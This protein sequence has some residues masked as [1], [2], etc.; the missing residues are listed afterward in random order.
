MSVLDMLELVDPRLKWAVADE[1]DV[2]PAD[3]L[4]GAGGTQAP[5]ARLYVDYLGGVEADGLAY[6]RAPAFIERSANHVGIGTRRPRADNE[7]IGE[8]QAVND[9]TK[10]GHDESLNGENVV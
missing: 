9:G 1:L 5:V 7:G 2:L 3:D 4:V 8:F 10:I 6:H